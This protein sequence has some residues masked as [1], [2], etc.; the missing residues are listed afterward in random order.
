MLIVSY[1]RQTGFNNKFIKKPI[2]LTNF[3]DVAHN[4]TGIA[5]LSSDPIRHAQ[6]STE[7]HDEMQIP[8]QDSNNYKMVLNTIETS[9]V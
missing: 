3:E 1:F 5:E 8:V 2:C 7:L 6:S 4:R 9:S